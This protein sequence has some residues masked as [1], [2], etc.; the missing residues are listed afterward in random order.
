MCSVSEETTQ[1]ALCNTM[2]A[3]IP[4][5]GCC[6]A[7]GFKGQQSK[8]NGP[9]VLV[10]GDLIS[11]AV[12]GRRPCSALFGSARLSVKRNAV[13]LQPIHGTKGINAQ[14]PS[15]IFAPSHSWGQLDAEAMVCQS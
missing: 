10:K 7:E 9:F 2:P 6:F 15:H 14:K 12:I 3:Q 11:S 8:P 13:Y 5:G 1:K 4:I